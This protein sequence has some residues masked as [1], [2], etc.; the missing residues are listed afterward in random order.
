MIAS[1]WNESLE[2]EMFILEAEMLE[3]SSSRLES[4][5][6]VIAAG[7]DIISSWFQ[8]AVLTSR[9]SSS[10]RHKDGTLELL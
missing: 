9:K 3:F 7:I 8:P 5:K 4:A 6:I 2:S 1:R 10:S